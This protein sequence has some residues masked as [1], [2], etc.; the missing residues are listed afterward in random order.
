MKKR[1]FSII[2]ALSLCV[3]LAVSAF[4]ATAEQSAAADE[5]YTLG[6]LRGGDGGFR[7]DDTAT[8]QEALT[9]IVRLLAKEETALSG[10]WKHP[11]TDVKAWAD[12]YVGYGYAKGLV[13]G[14]GAKTFGGE[15]DVSVSQYLVLVLRAL[16]YS[17]SAGDFTW[18]DPATLSVKLG[19][20]A[21]A[22]DA[23]S[24]T[25]C[26]RGKM[27]LITDNALSIKFKGADTAPLDNLRAY[28]AGDSSG[29][30][31]TQI[32]R[33]VAG[34]VFSID[35]YYDL[36]CE[37]H[38]A[39]GSGFFLT[40]DGVAVTNYHVLKGSYAARVE[41]VSGETYPVEGII[42]ADNLRDVAIIKV[43]KTAVD[44]SSVSRFPTVTLGRSALAEEGDPVYAFG[45]PLGQANTM[46][47]GVVSNICRYVDGSQFPYIQVSANTAKGSS[48]GALVNDRG[49]VI[50]ITSAKYNGAEDM[51]LCIPIDDTLS[52]SR[53]GPVIPMQSFAIAESGVEQD[54][55]CSLTAGKTS[56]TLKAGEVQGV[57]VS[58]DC[59]SAVM[60]SA[61]SSDETAVYA[62]FGDKVSDTSYMLFIAG[63]KPGTAAVT[64]KF[65]SGY[66]NH[67]ASAVINVTVTQ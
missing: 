36:D 52:L 22:K 24:G 30:S 55:K 19:L 6:L 60:L 29:L 20:I 58:T 47:D 14:V 54:V 4:A 64:V 16:G 23:A 67:D 27:V 40:A 3:S 34:A 50:G 45:S 25:P 10:T 9:M 61:E 37:L 11:F 17:E 2:L 12:G 8:R 65:L 33:K 59:K 42:S 32:A 49:E 41:L 43:S 48:G 57:L 13:K 26:T 62:G 56:V 46:T 28:L 15:K 7:L 66:G 53:T 44:G 63:I 18:R 21:S 39:V 35:T 51:T 1:I 31:S 5:L 38:F